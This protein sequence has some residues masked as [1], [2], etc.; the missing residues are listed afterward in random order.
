V[1]IEVD[2]AMMTNSP[3]LVEFKETVRDAFAYLGREFAFRETEPPA[4]HL[5]MNPFIIWFANE[6]TLVQV[7]GINWGFAAQVAIGPVGSRDEHA[8]VPLWAVIKHRRP[9][10]YEEFTR[11]TGQLGD[12]RA[13]ARALREVASDVL[14]GDFR[15]F[16]AARAI[17]EAQRVQLRESQRQESRDRNYRAAVTAASDAFRARDFGRVVELLMPHMELLTPAEHATLS[18]ARARVD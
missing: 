17:V 18:Y 2:G 16:A 11:S 13:Y 12:V 8:T 10:V 3:T 6:T 1:F 4:N 15:V 7:E 14:R 9:E 5:E